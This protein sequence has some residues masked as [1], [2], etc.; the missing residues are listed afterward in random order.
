MLQAT[1]FY[2]KLDVVCVV[3]ARMM[4]FLIILPVMSG[5][6]ISVWGKIALA[7]FTSMLVVSSG[8][9]TEVFYLNAPLGFVILVIKEFLVGIIMGF[10]VYVSFA[11]VYFAGQLLDFQIGFSMV[12]V[13]D[14]LTQVQVP[15]IGNLLFFLMCVL[16]V[17]SGGLNIF[18]GALFFSYEVLPP[19]IAVITGNAALLG[20]MLQLMSRFMNL[21]LCTAFPVM[22]AIL[23]IDAA[24]GLLVKA[25]PQMNVFV[26]GMPIKVMVGIALLFFVTPVFAD[27]Y[28]VIFEQGYTAMLS[29]TRGMIGY[30]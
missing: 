29:V 16:L 25:V 11:V 19:G 26:V 24:M 23:V 8:R 7:L 1:A 18:L 22:S 30:D 9:V 2:G 6:S 13:F 28:S 21:A 12:S 3:M 15:I 5:T 4:A 27:M 17:Q 14:P 20:D 10:M